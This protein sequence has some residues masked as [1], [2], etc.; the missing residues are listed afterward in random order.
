MVSGESRVPW[1]VRWVLCRNAYSCL[2]SP[3]TIVHLV[4]MFSPLWR[5]EAG[6]HTRMWHERAWAVRTAT[7]STQSVAN[8]G[9]EFEYSSAWTIILFTRVFVPVTKG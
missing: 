1:P 9:S 7:C 3:E 2:F 5:D 4:V 6:W 8:L